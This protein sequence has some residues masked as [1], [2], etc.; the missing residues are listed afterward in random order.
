M[1]VDLLYQGLLASP[2]SWARVG[3]ALVEQFGDLGLEVAAVKTR[4][5]LYA[6]EFRPDVP[7]LE[8]AQ[9]DKVAARFGLGFLHPPLI[10]RLRGRARQNLFVWEATRVPPA[11]IESFERAAV[12]VLVPSQ[13]TKSALVGSGLEPEQIRVIPYGYSE[14]W[15][16][17]V[18][19]E[20][21]LN[22]PS[23]RFEIL[24]VSAPHHRK[25][26]RELLLAYRLAFAP[27]DP[28]RL[29]IKTTYDPSGR[30]HP[31]EIE[32]WDHLLK[33][34]GP[35]DSGPLVRLIVGAT[36]AESLAKL[37]AEA[38]LYSAPSWGESFGLAVLDAAAA[39]IPCV[40][41]GWSGPTEFLPAGPDQLPFELANDSRA[42]YESVPGAECA[43]PDVDSLAERLR[44]HFE[45]RAESREIGRRLAESVAPLT[46]K[47]TASEIIK[48]FTE[49]ERE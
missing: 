7:E 35:F 30:P 36:S 23:D 25:G 44:F 21:A 1:K 37:Y 12:R 32:S 33:V 17:A 31:F 41:T 18:A 47:R 19:S 49:I 2:A 4:G 11:W 38:D 42:L 26:I 45:A 5:F 9:L 13:F 16:E 24:S 39:G 43:I 48:S 14:G 40:V 27:Q 22:R 3:R 29:T 28:V 6:D 15:P 34:C 20:R 10:A 46:W 8:A